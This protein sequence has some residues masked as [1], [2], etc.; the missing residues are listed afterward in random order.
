MIQLHFTFFTFLSHIFDSLYYVCFPG[1]ILFLEFPHKF[2]FTQIRPFRFRDFHFYCI[3]SPLLSVGFFL[4]CAR[5]AGSDHAPQPLFTPQ[6]PPRLAGLCLGNTDASLPTDRP[7]QPHAKRGTTQNISLPK[8]ALFLRML[9]NRFTKRSAPLFFCKVFYI[10]VVSTLQHPPPPRSA[11]PTPDSTASSRPDSGS[12]PS[13]PPR[14]T[15]F[16][17]PAS[18]HFSTLYYGGLEMHLKIR[19]GDE[20][21]GKHALGNR[22]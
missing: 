6:T 22:K 2:R 15:N 7:S 12:A 5:T 3:I 18:F 20:N 1:I 21:V 10:E 11:G 9:E 16:F 14:A 8:S 4:L 13:L 17:C 19:Y